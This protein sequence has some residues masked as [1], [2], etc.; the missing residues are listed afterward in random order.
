VVIRPY[1]YGRSGLTSRVRR[2]SLKSENASMDVDV[3]V[4]Q[5]NLGSRLFESRRQLNCE[6]NRYENYTGNLVFESLKS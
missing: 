2:V 3:D 6:R 5:W 4:D 1:D